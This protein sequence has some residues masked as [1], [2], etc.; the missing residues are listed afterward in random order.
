MKEAS[1]NPGSLTREDLE[2]F[3]LLEAAQPQYEE[4]L[5]ALELNELHEFQECST[6]NYRW[7]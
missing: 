2:V 7:D 6:D 3:D 1:E 4:Y 5:G